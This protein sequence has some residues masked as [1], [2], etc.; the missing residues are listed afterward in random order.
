MTRTRLAAVGLF[1][2][3]GA[4]LALFAI[5]SL[6]E[7]DP[8][9]HDT[10]AQI[11]FDGPVGGLAVGAPV[12]LSGVPVGY[13]TSIGIDYDPRTHRLYVP[14]RIEIQ[15][16]KVKLS[17]DSPGTRPSISAWVSQGLRARLLPVSLISG[18]T[19][20]D[21]DF[22]SSAAPQLHPKIAGLPEVPTAGSGGGPLAEQLSNLPLQQLAANANGAL[23]SMQRLAETLNGSLPTLLES[24]TRTS[25]MAGQAFDA[26]RVSLVRLQRRTNVTLNGIDRLTSAGQSQLQARGADLHA[27]LVSSNEAVLQARDALGSVESLTDTKSPARMNLDD[28]L[29][30]LSDASASLRGFSADI[31]QNPRLLLTGRSR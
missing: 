13:V 24:A 28:A 9:R 11:V 17:G 29:R 15:A 19:E 3:C 27:L 6:G 8:F 12:T 10:A 18:Q 16:D 14:V 23:Q 25:T 31:Q 22:D 4:A 30:D 2:L 7:M 26:A 1:V 21:L 20:V 5:I